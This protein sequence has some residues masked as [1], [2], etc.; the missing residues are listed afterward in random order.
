MKKYIIYDYFDNF[1]PGILGI[2]DTEAD[3]QELILAAA[4]EEAYN[5]FLDDYYYDETGITVKPG[6]NPMEI[7]LNDKILEWKEYNKSR[8]PLGDDNNISFYAWTLLMA[9]DYYN[10]SIGEEY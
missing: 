3:A 6:E 9:A 8:F 10:Y 2:C 5:A 1:Y 7:Y 4:E